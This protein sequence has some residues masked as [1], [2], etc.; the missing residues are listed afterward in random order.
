MIGRERVLGLITARGGSK[1]L[2]GKNIRPVQGR[3]LIDYTIAAGRSA[4][5]LDR[6]VLSTDD[7]AIAE[8]ARR[9]G[10]EVPFMRPPALAADG[11]PSI[12]VVVHALQA[13]PGFDIVVLLQPTSPAR[14]AEDIDA[15]VERLVASG[16]TS[17]VSVCAVLESPLWMYTQGPD[18]RLQALLPGQSASRRQDLPAVYTL[19]GAVYA[20]RVPQL[21]QSRSFLAAD[22]VA[23]LMPRE[24]SI[25]IDTLEDFD[26]FVRQQAGGT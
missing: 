17:C 7:E 20:A 26:A 16:A 12:D 23:H 9:C 15:T 4:R 1:G 19:N 3:P 6:L 11:T 10:C 22:T 21:L 18:G 2:P 13:L 5:S 8:V 24:R 14:S 25:D